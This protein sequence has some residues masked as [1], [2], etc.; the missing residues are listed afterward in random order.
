MELIQTLHNKLPETLACK[1]MLKKLKAISYFIVC[2]HLE[3]D[4]CMNVKAIAVCIWENK[5][6]FAQ[7]IIDKSRKSTKIDLILIGSFA[8]SIKVSLII[9]SLGF[10]GRI[11]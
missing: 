10:S 1:L 11:R 7:L 8:I 6:R 9:F 4:P 2:R 5:K 3:F